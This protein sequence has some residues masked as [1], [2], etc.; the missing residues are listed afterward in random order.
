MVIHI[1]N[2]GIYS[3]TTSSPTIP[4]TFSQVGLVSPQHAIHHVTV[5]ERLFKLLLHLVNVLLEL[6]QKSFHPLGVLG[7]VYDL[8]ILSHD[9]LVRYVSNEGEVGLDAI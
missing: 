3:L 6:D 5:Y 8:S 7:K 4:E 2:K 9:L 1:S